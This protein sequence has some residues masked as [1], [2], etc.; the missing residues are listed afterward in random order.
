[1]VK[2]I[3][4]KVANFPN[5]NKRDFFIATIYIGNNG[6]EMYYISSKGEILNRVMEDIYK[7]VGALIRDYTARGFSVKVVEK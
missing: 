7:E 3:I 4:V 1:M 5:S 6:A 2:N